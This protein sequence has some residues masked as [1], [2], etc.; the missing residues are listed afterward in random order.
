MQ[1]TELSQIERESRF[2]KKF[3]Q[4]TVEAGE[5]LSSVYNR[6]SLRINDMSRFKC[7]KL[8]IAS[9]AKREAKTHDPLALFANTHANEICDDQ[10]DSLTTAMML[11]ACGI[12]QRYSTP[13]NNRL[14]T[15]SKTRNQVVVQADRVNIQTEMLVMVV[16]LEEEQMLLAKKDEAAVILSDERN[17]FLLANATQ[18]EELEELSV[19][20][21]MMDGIQKAYSDSKDG[22]S[23]DFAFFKVNDGEVK[24]DN[25]AHDA[26]DNV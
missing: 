26:Q 14:R 9:R 22:P 17:D 3:D 7:E 10:E 13:T 23:Y 24:H 8:A 19:D 18:M 12:T 16:D 2:V 15:S 6:F 20:I 5:S 4:F 1:G 25:N 11:L 21:C